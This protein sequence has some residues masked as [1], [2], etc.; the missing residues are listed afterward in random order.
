[1]SECSKAHNRGFLVCFE[2]AIVAVG[3]FVAYWIDFGLFYVNSSVQ[4]RFPVAFQILFAIML[5]GALMLPDSPHWFIMQGRDEEA[6]QVMA[7]LMIAL[8]M[9]SMSWSAGYAGMNVNSRGIV[10]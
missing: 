5:T 4:W 3:T 10:L 2:G 1:M 7:H 8:L 9:T 6:L